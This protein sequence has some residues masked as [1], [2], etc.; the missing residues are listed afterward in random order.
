MLA[1]AYRVEMGF[2]IRAFFNLVVDVH[3]LLAHTNRL[4]FRH[5]MALK[6]FCFA[7]KTAHKFLTEKVKLWYFILWLLLG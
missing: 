1:H 5:Q 3:Y 7:A 4:E 6:A 2:A